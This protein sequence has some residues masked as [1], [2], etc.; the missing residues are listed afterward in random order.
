[1]RWAD[2]LV[3]EGVAAEDE[4]G[5]ITDANRRLPSAAPT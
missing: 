5:A 3:T 1:M 2:A 4:R